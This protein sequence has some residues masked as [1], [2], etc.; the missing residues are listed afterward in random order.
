MDK[1]LQ[2]H[3]LNLKLSEQLSLLLRTHVVIYVV[4]GIAGLGIPSV[5]SGQVPSTEMASGC[6]HFTSI[7][8]LAGLIRNLG[9]ALLLFSSLR[10]TEVAELF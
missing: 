4:S 8:V 5:C 10:K 1:I 2:T 3:E 9:L 7:P 6:N